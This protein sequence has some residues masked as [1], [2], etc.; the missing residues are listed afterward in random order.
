MTLN[1]PKPNKK[2]SVW[3]GARDGQALTKAEENVT[4]L[5]ERV[6]ALERQAQRAPRDIYLSRNLAIPF[7]AYSQIWAHSQLQPVTV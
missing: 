4:L 5:E 3:K 1:C 2:R 6:V 7:S